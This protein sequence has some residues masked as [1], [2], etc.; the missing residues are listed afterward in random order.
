MTADH[1]VRRGYALHRAFHNADLWIL[2]AAEGRFDEYCR[3]VHEEYA[4]VPDPLFRAARAQMLRDLVESTEIY[5]S[6]CG[7][8]HWDEPAGANVEPELARLS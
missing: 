8:A 1:P 3:Q 4:S 7:P 5:V 2:A 6:E